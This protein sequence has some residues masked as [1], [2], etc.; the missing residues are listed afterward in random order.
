MRHHPRERS[1]R[2]RVGPGEDER[3]DVQVG[4]PGKAPGKEWNLGS[5]WGWMEFRGTDEGGT[6]QANLMT[7]ATFKSQ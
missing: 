5:W 3:R 4:R 6:L 2:P 7:P 1:V